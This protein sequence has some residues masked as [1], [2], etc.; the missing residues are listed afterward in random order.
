MRPNGEHVVKM[1]CKM[2]T[3]SHLPGRLRGRGGDE[4]GEQR[5]R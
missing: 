4:T 2:T 5:L 1:S 3:W